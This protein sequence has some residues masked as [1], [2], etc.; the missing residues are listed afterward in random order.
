MENICDKVAKAISTEAEAWEAQA[1]ALAEADCIFFPSHLSQEIACNVRKISMRVRNGELNAWKD[2]LFVR[3][4]GSANDLDFV[5]FARNTISSAR[6]AS[7]IG[8]E[9]EREAW[10]AVADAYERAAEAWEVEGR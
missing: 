9:T 3:T 4:G 8:K 6:K 7:K 10:E 1:Q 2:L 5:S